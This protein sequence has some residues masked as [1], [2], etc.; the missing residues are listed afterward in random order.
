MM[1]MKATKRRS[2]EATEGNRKFFFPSSLR[3]FAPSLLLTIIGCTY[4]AGPGDPPSMK[5]KQA[6]VANDPIS[7][8][9]DNENTQPYDISGGGI[10]NFDSK[11]IKKDLD[12]VLDP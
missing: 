9:P 12:H 11:G 2:D 8:K 3:R 5:Q 10:N 7:Y 1:K 6:Q 4:Q